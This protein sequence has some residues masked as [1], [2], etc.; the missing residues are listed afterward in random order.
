[1]SQTDKLLKLIT[2]DGCVYISVE[3]LT[4][5]ST[6]GCGNIVIKL[7]T[8]S[9][10]FESKEV[11]NLTFLYDLNINSCT[12]NLIRR[13]IR[14]KKENKNLIVDDKIK[15]I[16]TSG[17]LAECSDTFGG[18]QCVDDCIEKHFE[19]KY[20]PVNSLQDVEKMYDWFVV[21]PYHLTRVEGPLALAQC[22][23]DGYTVVGKDI[24]NNGFSIEYHC[25]KKRKLE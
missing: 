20:N 4:S 8:D 6:Y 7:A 13:I 24:L 12:F 1:M 19:Q 25:R 18:F 2:I 23:N 11:T 22:Q 16:I 15:E 14:L 21:G 17:E 5:L 3:E 9:F 10:D